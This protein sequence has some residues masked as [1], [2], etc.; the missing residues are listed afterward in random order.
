M[1]LSADN[2]HRDNAASNVCSFK[3][4]RNRTAQASAI[5]I[6][7]HSLT[8]LLGLDLTLPIGAIKS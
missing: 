1:M 4:K 3:L 7:A 8:V 2:S 6:V 5:D